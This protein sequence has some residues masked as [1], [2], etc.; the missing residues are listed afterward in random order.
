MLRH[1]FHDER[2][3]NQITYYFRNIE[4][5]L[6]THD[7]T[8]IKFHEHHQPRRAKLLM[9]HILCEEFIAFLNSTI[10]G[11]PI[12]PSRVAK[13]SSNG[14]EDMTLSLSISTFLTVMFSLS[15]LRIYYYCRTTI[16][17]AIHFLACRTSPAIQLYN[18]SLLSL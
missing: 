3:A 10:S 12:A 7:R 1:F 2:I 8:L 6:L 16:S 17:L 5:G 18:V 13:T 9:D 14:L 15:Y 11:W 4:S